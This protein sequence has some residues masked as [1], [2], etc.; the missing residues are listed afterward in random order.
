[1]EQLVRLL[2]APQVPDNKAVWAGQVLLGM[3]S[4][5]DR[6]WVRVAC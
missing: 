4:G 5:E 2:S 6:Y 3:V 1:M